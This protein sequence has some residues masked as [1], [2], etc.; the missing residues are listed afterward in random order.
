M[1]PKP[2]L[3]DVKIVAFEATRVAALKHRGDPNTIGKSVRSLIEWRKQNK[4]PP[5]RHATYNIL[6][7]P[8]G[9]LAPEDFR[10]D[11]CVA[12]S[13]PIAENALGIVEKIIPGGRCAVLRHTGSEDLLEDSVK[14]LYA[15]WLP[16]SG[17]ELRDAPPF[18]QRVAFAPFVA[19]NEQVVDIFLPIV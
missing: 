7:E 8:P 13:Q 11:L 6:Y 2:T 12:T 19:D 14:F 16:Q 1:H 9:E 17:E 3:A 15:T 18:F 10:I 4:L 5:A